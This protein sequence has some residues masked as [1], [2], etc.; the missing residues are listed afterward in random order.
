MTG[1]IF[2][3]YRREDSSDFAKHMHDRLASEFGQNMVFIDIEDCNPLGRRWDDTLRN[4]VVNCR[5]LLALIGPNWLYAQDKH[6]NRRLSDPEDVVRFEIRVAL[7]RDIPVIPVLL[8]G[9]RIPKFDEL[10]D[11]LEELVMRHG[12]EVRQESLEEN[13]DK[14]ILGIKRLLSK[15]GSVVGR[16]GAD[17]MSS[18]LKWFIDCAACPVYITNQHLK[19]LYCND[20]LLSFLGARRELIV[21]MSV[22]KIIYYFAK[23]VPDERQQAFI[24]LQA[25][26]LESA[27]TVP[28]AALAE[29]VDLSNRPPSRYRGMYGVWAQ[30]HFVYSRQQNLPLGSVVL[31]HLAEVIRDQSGNFILPQLARAG[32]RPVTAAVNSPARQQ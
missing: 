9:A 2:L 4:K 8:G 22:R 14:L 31:Y 3:S 12:V 7:Q 32:S 28:D 29:V 1:T 19:V 21:G 6:G 23:L 25:T 13:L 27:S 30:A 26:V 10:P 11:D 20:H 24:D 18:K 15:E 5:V 16:K 17:I